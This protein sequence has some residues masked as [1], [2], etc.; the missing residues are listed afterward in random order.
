MVRTGRQAAESSR[1]QVQ[2]QETN[3]GQWWQACSPELPTDQMLM[4]KGCDDWEGPPP[5]VERQGMEA[6]ARV[7]NGT[8]ELQA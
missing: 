2:Q 7:E 4:I 8:P 5:A 1:W 6:Q 3:D